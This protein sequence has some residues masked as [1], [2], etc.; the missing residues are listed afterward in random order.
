LFVL[1]TN[2]VITRA[3]GQLC[4][5]VL[6]VVIKNIV[7]GRLNERIAEVLNTNVLETAQELDCGKTLKFW[8]CK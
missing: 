3:I 4:Y 1:S 6:F 8:T 2:A 7:T 5:L